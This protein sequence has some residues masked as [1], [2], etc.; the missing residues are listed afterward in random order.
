MVID[1]ATHAELV[2]K[3]TEAVAEFFPNPSVKNL[4]SRIAWAHKGP[5][6]LDSLKVDD[7]CTIRGPAYTVNTAML[8]AVVRFA[9]EISEN[10]T[11]AS[12]QILGEVPEDQRIFWLY[13]LSV[14]S[15]IAFPKRE[16]VV[17][18]YQ[19][20][21]DKVVSRWPDKDFEAHRSTA[22]GKIDLL[23]YALC[24][25]EKMNTERE[26]CVRN[27]TAMAPIREIEARF[28]IIKDGRPLAGYESHSI[29][30]K[31]GGMDAGG[32]PLIPIVVDFFNNHPS[33]RIDAVEGAIR[34]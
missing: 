22:D 10:H 8:A 1:R 18:D 29:Y 31:G 9:D 11:R 13:A 32:Y 33:W 6:S 2:Y 12:R 17:V 4:V 16:R 15:C 5:R 21:A 34:T 20:D 3:M 14:S 7:L 19:F 28:S 23:T 26:Y 30:L 25:L 24:R 27:F